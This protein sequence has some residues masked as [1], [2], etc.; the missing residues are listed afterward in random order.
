MTEL[1]K[2]PVSLLSKSLCFFD[3]EHELLSELLETPVR[4]QIKT[5]EAEKKKTHNK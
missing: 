4:W 2:S 5:I 3:G 1:C